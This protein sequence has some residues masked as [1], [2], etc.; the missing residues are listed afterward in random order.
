MPMPAMYGM[1]GGM[2]KTTVY[3]TGDQKAALTRAAQEE[4]RSEA[5]LIRA[6]IDAVTA[7]H[8]AGEARAALGDDPSGTAREVPSQARPRW[9]D[10]ETFVRSVL[11]HQADAGLRAELR[12]LA[13]GTTDDEPLP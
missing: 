9:L 1:M 5:R 7:R 4:G 2:E 10:R 13:P 12:D 8:R 6:G 3:L 11:R